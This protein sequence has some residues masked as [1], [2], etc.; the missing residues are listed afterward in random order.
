MKKAYVE[1]TF[2][3]IHCRISQAKNPGDKTILC[4][5]PMPFSGLFFDTITP[6]LTNNHRVI[7]PDYPGYGASDRIEDITIENWAESMA[8]MLKA[9]ELD[10]P[11]AVVGFHSGCLVATELSLRHPELVDKLLLI[12]VPYFNP[13]QRAEMAK[14]NSIP[15]KITEDVSCIE[16]IWQMN[17]GSKLGKVPVNRVME[18]LAEHLRNGENANLG[19]KAAFSYDAD[20]MSNI[21]HPTLVLA[22]KWSLHNASLKTAS[23][24]STST[25]VERGDFDAP[26]FELH[27]QEIAEEVLTYIS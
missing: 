27:A 14:N 15:P 13:Q 23:L 10:H 16:G 17:V 1:T 4:L 25:L 18:S 21:T 19:F 12:D 9:L 5:H 6:H 3:Q 20:K 11:V 24:I 7:S 22:S 8:A 2:G 26:I